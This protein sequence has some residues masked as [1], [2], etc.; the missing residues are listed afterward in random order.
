MSQQ[1]YRGPDGIIW[2]VYRVRPASAL[3]HLPSAFRDG[4]LTFESEGAKWRV[5][6][7]PDAWERLDGA[8]LERLRLTGEPQRQL[9]RD[10]PGIDQVEQFTS[11]TTASEAGSRSA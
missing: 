8:T 3:T 10:M 6:P 4:W 9:G 2:S 11:K 7:V 5:A 1:K